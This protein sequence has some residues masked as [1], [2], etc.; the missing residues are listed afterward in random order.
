MRRT[1]RVSPPAPT[2]DESRQTLRTADR[3]K[4]AI[5]APF[6]ADVR[7]PRRA[8]R[9]PIAG[10]LRANC[11]RITGQSTAGATPANH[12]STEGGRSE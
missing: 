9:Q 4:R 8:L 5:S 2:P 10:F 6:P 12:Q 11:A 7:S 3:R 1:W